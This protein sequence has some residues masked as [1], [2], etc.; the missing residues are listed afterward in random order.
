[1][2]RHSPSPLFAAAPLALGFLLL[3]GCTDTQE[4]APAPPSAA[5]AACKA[6]GPAALSPCATPKQSAAYYVDQANRYFDALDADA[7]ADST[8]TYAELVARWEWP[9]WLKLTGFT[10]EQLESTDK[11]VKKFAPANV[12]HRDCRAFASQP[13]ARCRVSFDYQDQGNGKPCYIYEEFTFNDQGEQTFIEAWS[14]LPGM[15]PILDPKDPWGEHTPIHRLSTRIPGLGA[16]TGHIDLDGAA[17]QSAA[18][19]DPEVA[20]FVARAKD[21]WPSFAAEGQVQGP[22]YFDRGCGW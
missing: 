2:T 4:P 3:A 10:R 1:M 20:D 13:F 7:P 12:S 6:A 17:M 15:T 11:V 22:D 18:A 9:P 16:A 5:A 19:K 21:F 8:P 14:D